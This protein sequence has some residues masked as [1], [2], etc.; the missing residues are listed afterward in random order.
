MILIN[1]INLKLDTDFNNLKPII[2]KELKISSMK[3][4]KAHRAF[5]ALNL[6]VF[7]INFENFFSQD[8]PTFGV[9]RIIFFITKNM[10]VK[11][12]SIHSHSFTQPMNVILAVQWH[13]G[14]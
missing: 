4:G 3:P 14:I 6:S 8:F 9:P 1:N 12:T 11:S 10:I 5:C 2:A 7:F 13:H